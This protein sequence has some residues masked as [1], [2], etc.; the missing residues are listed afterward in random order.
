MFQHPDITIALSEQHRHDLVSD[1]AR[2]RLVRTMKG[3]DTRLDHP[4]RTRRTWR[5]LVLRRSE[6]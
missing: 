5:F 1:A 4:T 2:R 3:T 6:A